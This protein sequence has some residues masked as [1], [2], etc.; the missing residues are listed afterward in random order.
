LDEPIKYLSFLYIIGISFFE[1]I[2]LNLSIFIVFA[3]SYF[4]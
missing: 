4:T 2:R 3:V 1:M